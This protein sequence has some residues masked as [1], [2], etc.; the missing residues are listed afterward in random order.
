MWDITFYTSES[1][2]VP[3]RNFIQKKLNEDQRVKLR[4]RLQLL[5][6]HGPQMAEEYPKALKRLKGRKYRNIYEIRVAKDQLRVFLFFIFDGETAVL[7]HAIT[8]A[9][10]GKKKINDQYEI[11]WTRRNEWLQRRDDS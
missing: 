10:K 4:E 8:K 2:R 6:D 9:G 7:V 5:R 3:V 11:A 1:G